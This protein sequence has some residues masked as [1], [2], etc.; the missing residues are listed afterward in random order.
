MRFWFIKRESA[1]FA[2]LL[3][4]SRNVQSG[5]SENLTMGSSYASVISVGHWEAGAV[6]LPC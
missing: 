5:H 3:A 4:P 6:K 1:E 2:R